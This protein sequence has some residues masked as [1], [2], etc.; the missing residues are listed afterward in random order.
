MEYLDTEQLI[1]GF[2]FG[3]AVFT[4]I[5][6]IFPIVVALPIAI[7]YSVIIAMFGFLCGAATGL[8]IFIQLTI[9]VHRPYD[10][11]MSRSHYRIRKFLVRKI[12]KII[13]LLLLASSVLS[14][15]IDLNFTL[16]L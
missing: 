15:L 1:F 14:I 16:F 12:E 4:C 7:L 8:R 6:F 3:F 5:F 13:V 11:T 10:P 9:F 2:L